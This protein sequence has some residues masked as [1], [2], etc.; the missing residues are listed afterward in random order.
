MDRKPIR[1]LLIEDNAG[2]A[3]LLQEMLNDTEGIS[4]ELAHVGRLSKGLEHLS[5]DGADV[6]LLDLSLPDS[7]GL[8]TF[9]KVDAHAPQVPIVVLSGLDDTEVAVQAVREGAQ[10]YLVKGQ[11]NCH[12]LSRAVPYA[13]ERKRAE[14]EIRRRAAHLEALNA[15]IAKAAAASDLQ[16]LLETALDHTLHALSLDKGAIWRS[17]QYF[18]R[19]I[20]GSEH[21]AKAHEALAAVGCGG[22]EARHRG[23]GFDPL[24]HR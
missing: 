6:V 4:F 17:G 18:V 2:D 24:R 7:K 19:G 8:D 20:S 11:T 9:L 1:I 21:E 12:L 22:D 3:R 5:D 10:D 16:D 14:E 23:G 13:I 15:V